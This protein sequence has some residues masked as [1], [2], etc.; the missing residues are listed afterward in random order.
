MEFSESAEQ[1]GRMARGHQVL[2]ILHRL[3][4]STLL[5]FLVQV[6]SFRNWALAMTS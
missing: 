4:L 3:F 2:W 6:S 1:P 5:P